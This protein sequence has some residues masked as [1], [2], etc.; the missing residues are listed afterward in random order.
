MNIN[1]KNSH[2][3]QLT[4]Q[5]R[6]THHDQVGFILGIQSW[7]NNKK[8]ISVIQRIN[9][10][11]KEKHHMIISMDTEKTW[12]NSTITYDKN[13]QQTTNRRKYPQ[14]NKAYLQNM[15]IIP[16]DKRLNAFSLRSVTRYG[17]P[18]WPFISNIILE[19]LASA[20]KQE[21]ETEGIQKG[22]QKTGKVEIALST[23]T[24]DCLCGK[25]QGIYK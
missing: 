15:N 25:S 11:K 18:L 19:V 12:Q 7:I 24:H 17:C 14:N 1:A 10:V 6:I 13:S 22:K 16:N 23:Y 4:Y 2:W 5:Y 8:S 20:V 9:S 21:K 3:F